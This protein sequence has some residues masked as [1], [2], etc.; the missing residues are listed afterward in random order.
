MLASDMMLVMHAATVFVL[1]GCWV[2]RRG[3]EVVQSLHVL[4]LRN[5]MRLSLPYSRLMLWCMLI[6]HHC[7]PSTEESRPSEVYTYRDEY[8]ITTSDLNF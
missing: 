7:H 6:C 1:G 3:S 8:E 4:S 2:P 5:S